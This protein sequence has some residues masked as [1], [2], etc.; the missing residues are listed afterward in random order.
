MRRKRIKP[1]YVIWEAVRVEHGKTIEELK[2]L[3]PELCTTPASQVIVTT[4]YVYLRHPD[5]YGKGDWT[6][7]PYTLVKKVIR[8]DDKDSSEQ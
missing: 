4:D 1:D 3:P 5:S 8:R 2:Q 6:I 7:I